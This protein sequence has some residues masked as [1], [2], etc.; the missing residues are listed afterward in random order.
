M[1]TLNLVSALDEPVRP[2]LHLWSYLCIERDCL[3]PF[4]FANPYAN[5]LYFRRIPEWPP[6][7]ELEPRDWHSITQVLDRESYESVLLHGRSS[8][9][10]SVLRDSLEPVASNGSGILFVR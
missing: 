5:N 2:N 10:E 9:G 8:E 7:G 3:S 4:L 6:E 1:L